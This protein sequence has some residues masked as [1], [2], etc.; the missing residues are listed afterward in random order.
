MRLNVSLKG[1]IASGCIAAVIF[2]II[3][4]ATGGRIGRAII[5]AVILGIVVFIISFVISRAIIATRRQ[6]P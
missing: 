4:A 1:N 5:E 3:D 6:H 2:F